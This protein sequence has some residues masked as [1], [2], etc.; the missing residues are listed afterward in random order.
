MTERRKLNGVFTTPKTIGYM[1]IWGVIGSGKTREEVLLKKYAHIDGT[2]V[3]TWNH[4]IGKSWK[5]LECIVDHIDRGD[6]EF[7]IGD[8]VETTLEYWKKNQELPGNVSVYFRGV[9]EKV[10]GFTV[11]VRNEHGDLQVKDSD[12]QRII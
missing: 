4:L 6:R 5:E 10:E 9:V 8:E 12:L 1:S 11:T 3:V 7:K 2:D